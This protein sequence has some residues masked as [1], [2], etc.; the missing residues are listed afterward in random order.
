MSLKLI[1][2]LFG[3]DVYITW[4]SCD[5]H[6]IYL[7]R[8]VWLSSNLKSVT[9]R[10]PS[11]CS[12][13]WQCNNGRTKQN[14]YRKPRLSAL[15]ATGNYIHVIRFKQQVPHSCGWEV[16]SLSQSPARLRDQ[17]V[18]RPVR[19]HVCPNCGD[20]RFNWQAIYTNKAQPHGGLRTQTLRTERATEE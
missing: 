6:Y 14:M 20:K 9:S 16:K 12:H 3:S 11:V 13:P 5:K 8:Y 10:S 1:I 17:E 15:S 18:G 4:Y 7:W 19:L 2:N